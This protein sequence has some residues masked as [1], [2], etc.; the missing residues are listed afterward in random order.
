MKIDYK[1][2]MNSKIFVGEKNM[3]LQL[4]LDAAML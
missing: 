2:L 4:Y 3:H 1:S